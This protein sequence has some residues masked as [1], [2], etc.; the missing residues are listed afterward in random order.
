M[1]DIY[2][3]AV[4]NK[5]ITVKERRQIANL[6]EGLS[7]IMKN[8]SLPVLLV[9]YGSAPD[10]YFSKI[11]DYEKFTKTYRITHSKGFFV[12]M[13]GSVNPGY[14]DYHTL[15]YLQTFQALY[16]TAEYMNDPVYKG[17]IIKNINTEI[18][19]KKHLYITLAP[20]NS[21]VPGQKLN[22]RIAPPVTE[23]IFTKLKKEAPSKN[24][25]EERIKRNRR[26]RG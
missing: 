14:K 13:K 20:D 4:E 9:P 25:I 2:S 12:K 18:T 17:D 21:K 6:K 10:N 22:N 26:C 16:I 11:L 3:L 15:A 19:S 5:K 8:P 7:G 24:I 23:N 1:F